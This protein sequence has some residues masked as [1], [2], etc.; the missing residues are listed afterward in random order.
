MNSI[1]LRALIRLNRIILIPIELPTSANEA[2]L[3]LDQTL[4]DALR[5][6]RPPDLPDSFFKEV[7]R[8]S[9]SELPY[10]RVY[11]HWSGRLTATEVG[12]GPSTVQSVWRFR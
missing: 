12:R 4:R 6:G 8:K 2:P 1:A 5:S 7:A 11:T 10:G 3:G 9:T